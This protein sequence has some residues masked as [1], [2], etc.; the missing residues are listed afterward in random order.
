LKVKLKSKINNFSD[1]AKAGG[2]LGKLPLLSVSAYF[3]DIIIF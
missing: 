2:T 1:A 3:I